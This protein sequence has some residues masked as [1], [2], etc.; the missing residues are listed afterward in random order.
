MNKVSLQ[1]Y[2]MVPDP[3]KLLLSHADHTFSEIGHVVAR[4]FAERISSKTVSLALLAAMQI[5]GLD[6]GLSS[7]LQTFAL[8]LPNSRTQELEGTPFPLP[9]RN[10]Y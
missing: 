3:F 7:L 8:E 1:S 6:W 2:H 10:A 4:H 5:L 9:S